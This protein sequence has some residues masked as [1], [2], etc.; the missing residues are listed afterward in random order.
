MQN[1]TDEIESII[2]T[3]T[4]TQPPTPHLQKTLH[5]QRHFVPPLLQGPSAQE[6]REKIWGV[7]R[8]YTV[9]S[10]RILVRILSARNPPY[11]ATCVFSFWRG[12]MVVY[13]EESDVR[14]SRAVFLY[15]V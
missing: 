7:Y 1:P 5:P 3:L 13:D 12:E 2:T 9:M 10:P 11:I 15:S 6:S 4:S 14:R 8:W